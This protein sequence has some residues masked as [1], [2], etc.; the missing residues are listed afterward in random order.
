MPR[1]AMEARHIMERLR[2]SQKGTSP[3]TNPA[4]RLPIEW[5]ESNTPLKE[6][7]SP[8]LRFRSG[9]ADPSIRETRPLQ[10][11]A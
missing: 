1:N 7:D 10:K 5:A 2:P 4:T 3:E 8:Q 11:K 9:M 6:S